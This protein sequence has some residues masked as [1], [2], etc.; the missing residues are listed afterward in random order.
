MTYC[1]ARSSRR[2]PC[3]NRSAASA[4]SAKA[5]IIGLTARLDELAK[6][7]LRWS[8]FVIM[9]S[10]GLTRPL[11]PTPSVCPSGVSLRNKTGDGAGAATG[12]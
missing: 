7:E 8:N 11:L 6:F 9:E 4:T 5:L 12:Y 10:D 3:G 1:D 2:Q